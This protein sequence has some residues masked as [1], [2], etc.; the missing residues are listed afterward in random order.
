VLA[1]GLA[2]LSQ[3]ILWVGRVLGEAIAEP[4]RARRLTDRDGRRLQQIMRRGKQRARIR[5][6][7]QHRWRRLKVKAA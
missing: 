7:R 4:V 5:S 6:E 3:S 1:A 2:G